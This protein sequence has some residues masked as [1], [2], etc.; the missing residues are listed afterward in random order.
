MS[1]ASKQHQRRK[2]TVGGANALKPKA[3]FLKTSNSFTGTMFNKAKFALPHTMKHGTSSSS[4]KRRS[5]KTMFTRSR[6]KGIFAVRESIS[7]KRRK[8]DALLRQ[9]KSIWERVRIRLLHSPSRLKSDLK[10]ASVAIGMSLLKSSCAFRKMAISIFNKTERVAWEKCVVKLLVEEIESINALKH[11]LT[12][13]AFDSLCDRLTVRVY[14]DNDIIYQQNDP[15]TSKMI[16]LQ[17]RVL[18]ST[19]KNLIRTL[20]EEQRTARSSQ[21]KETK[22]AASSRS[23]DGWKSNGWESLITAANSKIDRFCKVGGT[24]GSRTNGENLA[25]RSST[26]RAMS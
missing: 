15:S 14:M 22:S 12:A 16:V 2:S 11:F 25:V 13:S 23:H 7:M 24:F 3:L 17:G 10:D 18:L 6:R 19:Q 26:A 8:R 5:R 4:P 20:C 9:S 1:I 21:T